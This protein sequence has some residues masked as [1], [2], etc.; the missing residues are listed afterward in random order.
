MAETPLPS[1]QATIV[2]VGGGAIKILSQ[3]TM[4]EASSWAKCVLVDTDREAIN[5]HTGTE[6]LVIGD[7]WAHGQGCGGDAALGEKACASSAG[8]LRSALAQS[9][10]VL[11]VACLGKGV[12]SGAVQTL[13]RLVRELDLTAF[14]FV[15]MP[16]AAEGNRAREVAEQSLDTLRRTADV[17]VAI[18]ND[19]LFA[20]VPAQTRVSDAF[21][22]S[23]TLLANG[24]IGMA[25]L[26][27]CHGLI[28]VDFADVR[29]LLKG[30][31]AYCSFGIGITNAENR[32]THVVDELLASPLLG[33][34]E[35]LRTTNTVVVTLL[36][37]DDMSIG[38]MNECLETLHNR[39]SQSIRSIVGANAEPAR[40]GTLQLTMLAIEYVSEP[41]ATPPVPTSSTTSPQKRPAKR[42][43]NQV[44][45]RQMPLPFDEESVSVGIFGN[46]PATMHAD[47]NL[48]IPTFQRLGVKLDVES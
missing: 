3:P 30:R 46:T 9:Q 12:G 10:L 47:Q 42:R 31:R 21:A 22:A 35:S 18:R 1:N 17:V 41:N 38:E 36:G 5:G 7:E 15:T 20:T 32:T 2:G 29:A 8:P 39:L 26:V 43:R 44:P 27:R 6:T 11:I 48:D 34:E 37:G 24:I 28:S 19:L 25:E 13:S 4:A 40:R 14:F 23:N 33:G 16:M 45:T